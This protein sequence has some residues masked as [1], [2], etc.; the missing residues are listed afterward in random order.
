MLRA[1]PLWSEDLGLSGRADVVEIDG[2]AVRPVGYKSG[3]PHGNAANLQLCAQAL[4]LE[5]MLGVEAGEGGVWFGGLKRRV[6]IE[7]TANLR[8]EVTRTVKSIRRQLL[9]VALPDAPNDE[10][11][12]ECQLLK[13]CLPALTSAPERVNAYLEDSVFRCA[14]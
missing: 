5:E 2:G 7:F 10:R 4:C 14:A 13:Y 9:D 12:A 6:R 8:Q 1:I 11:C 3:V